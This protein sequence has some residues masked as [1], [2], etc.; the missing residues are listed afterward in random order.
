[1]R[2]IALWAAPIA[3]LATAVHAS[4]PAVPWYGAGGDSS[5]STVTATGT[6]TPRSLAAM[7]ADQLN[8]KSFGAKGDFKFG[9]TDGVISAG[10]TSF[11][12]STITFTSA[13]IGKTI[14]ESSIGAT[15]QV[16]P[17]T[18]FTPYQYDTTLPAMGRPQAWISTIT[19]VSAGCA[20]V[21]AGPTLAGPAYFL[22]DW[23]NT[24][25]PGV[26]YAPGDKLSISGGTGQVTSAYGRVRLTKIVSATVAAGGSGG[27]NGTCTVKGTT[28]A[29]LGN[30]Q[31]TYNVTV[32]GGAITAI[33]SITNTGLYTTDPN[34]AEGAGGA[35]T[36]A[37]P[38]TGC[39]NIVGATITQ[40]MGVALAAPDFTQASSTT[41][42]F[43][44]WN[45]A[46]A[47]TLT[48][49]ATTGV[50]R[51]FTLSGGLTGSGGVTITGWGYG[52]DDTAALT[53][54]IN[55]E[56]TLRAAGVNACIYVPAGTYL[57]APSSVVFSGPGCVRGDGMR[58]SV[59][60]EKPNTAGRLFTWS[61]TSQ[62]TTG[63]TAQSAEL[64]NTGTQ[65]AYFHGVGIF[66]DRSSGVT[67]DALDFAD[68]NHEV[69]IGDFEV[70]SV[71]GRCLS[72]GGLAV[73]N[74]NGASTI[75]ESRVSN[76]RIWNC[77]DQD[78][79]LPPLE[80][81]TAYVS[82][83]GAHQDSNETRFIN[84][85]IYYSYGPGYWQH[86][87]SSNG[88][89][90]RSM[91]GANIRIETGGNDQF[92]IN[93]DNMV[94][95]PLPTNQGGAGETGNPY[96]SS[97]TNVRLVN[98]SLGGA[99]LRF[100][101]LGASP[102]VPTNIVWEG[103][104]GYGPAYGNGIEVDA[105]QG[106]TILADAIVA[107][108]A[109]VF[110]GPASP[111]GPYIIAPVAI[112]TRG[113]NS[114]LIWSV[115]ST[116]YGS[117][118]LPVDNPCSISAGVVT[119]CQAASI[120]TG[121]TAN[122]GGGQTNAVLLSSSQV[123]V[124]TTVGSNGDS[125]MLP[126]ATLGSWIV[127]ANDGSANRYMSVFPSSGGIINRQ[128]AN[129]SINLGPG[130]AVNCVS[131]FA[132]RWACSPTLTGVSGNV[133][134]FSSNGQL[135]DSGSPLIT[136][137]NPSFP[138]TQVFTAANNLTAHAG[139][140]QGSCLA[141]TS[142]INNISSVATNGDSVCLPSAGAGEIVVV[143]NQVASKY[144]A[145]FPAS[146]DNINNLGANTSV[147]LGGQSAITFVSSA[148]GK[149]QAFTPVVGTAGDFLNLNSSGFMQ[150]AGFGTGTSGH[151]IPFLDGT[152]TWSGANG[153]GTLTATT[154]NG[155]TLTTT[156]GTFTLTNGKTLSVSNTLTFA[157]TDSTTH[158]FPNVSSTVM[159]LSSTDTI[160][161]TKTFSTGNINFTGAGAL[162][163]NALKLGTGNP[164]SSCTVPSGASG[165][166][167]CTV[168]K[169]VGTFRGKLTFSG[170][171][172][173]FTGTSS[174]VT[175]PN[176]ASTD[177]YYC[178]GTGGASATTLTYQIF[179]VPSSTT[180]TNLYYYTLAG[181]ATSPG[182][183]D[184][185][186]IECTSE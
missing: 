56:N 124:V 159:E 108:A 54:A 95:G 49:T 16:A 161:G 22:M 89:N 1:M 18:T 112:D 36:S 71:R 136:T 104:V 73:N 27:A 174:T 55:Q 103:Q 127:V 163:A 155:L 162:E 12:S 168:T 68:A 185:E 69:D 85:D 93:Y 23:S 106:I 4:A 175:F 105:G 170:G 126:P 142:V 102:T 72:L 151:L 165:S 153:F 121:L 167:I 31:A 90:T 50:G 77:G 143:A 120:T 158:T 3:A 147:N 20:T 35:S 118:F 150:D 84:A 182:L 76:F 154:L 86:Y 115:D 183:T 45:T 57:A 173:S 96:A 11:C 79:G 58:Q 141:L 134:T 145:V 41:H 129:A 70:N 67:Q 117:L 181:V 146:G 113:N 14:I 119:L 39:G 128:S 8:L 46:P 29:W 135:Q 139:G 26:G 169:S 149:W 52:T 48:T 177:G 97:F 137:T 15:T 75:A 164:I 63:V 140:G 2:R 184:V 172:G 44:L 38:V 74:T 88:G 66:G 53:A 111:S 24:V 91:I 100:N 178:K 13:D 133:A 61:N 99:G 116:T 21:A 186:S 94:F 132:G 5:A 144:V 171:S 138:V 80:V 59:I 17:A 28:G 9:Y 43:G 180:V 81:N 114:S 107:K 40:H 33:N 60:W 157:G 34:N 98:P 51:G 47:A 62:N 122:P 65:G 30:Q 123:N 156:T 6:T 19:G 109:A 148:S 160:T 37:E 166:P 42:P 110:V 131:G 179:G 32:S 64:L 82:G 25:A 10:G 7:A 130:A 92:R 125:V 101:A 87:A 152:N 78:S 176:A 83:T